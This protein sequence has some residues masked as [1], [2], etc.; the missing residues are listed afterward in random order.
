MHK[1][2]PIPSRWGKAHGHGLLRALQHQPLHL[3]QQ[4]P[5][6][7]PP[8]PAEGSAPPAPPSAPPPPP[9]PET[10]PTPQAG[11]G[12]SPTAGSDGQAPQPSVQGYWREE[13]EFGLGRLTRTWGHVW[14]HDG[15]VTV[16]SW[17]GEGWTPSGAM[18][19]PIGATAGQGYGRYTVRAKF[20]AN[21]PGQFIC[22]WPASDEWVWEVDLV[23]RDGSGGAYSTVHWEGAAGSR[24]W[25]LPGVDPAEPHTYELLWQRDLLVLSVD[26][27]ELWRTTEHVPRD[28]ADGGQNMCFGAGTQPAQ[29]A[30]WLAGDV[31][32]DVEFMKYQPA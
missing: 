8:G 11:N 25:P 29:W 19:A 6:P 3:H 28:A 12:G 26:G 23:E 16:S 18:Q 27:V 10:G 7:Q 5:H 4:R 32:L 21:G 14:V 1:F 15:V 20:G 22:G 30:A 24:S 31:V 2:P 9:P 17:A 13:F